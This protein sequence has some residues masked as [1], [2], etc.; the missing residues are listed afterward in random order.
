MS[1]IKHIQGEMEENHQAVSCHDFLHFYLFQGARSTG[2]AAV[3]GHVLQAAQQRRVVVGTNPLGRCLVLQGH[4]AFPAAWALP[5]ADHA[6]DL[7]EALVDGKVGSKR[8]QTS[9]S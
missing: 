7:L 5:R 4:A 9:A 2:G 6:V 8:G 1:V 3:I